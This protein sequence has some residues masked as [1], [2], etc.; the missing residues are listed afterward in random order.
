MRVL[1]SATF[2]LLAAW[3]LA[4]SQDQYRASVDLVHVPVVVLGRDGAPVRGLTK[5]DFEVREDGRPQ[6]VS[7][8]IEGAPGESLPLHVGLLLDTSESMTRDLSDAA[9]AAIQ[10]VNAL[11]ESI[12]ATLVDFDTTVRVGRFAPASYPHMF[13]RIRARKA[14]GM[15]ALWDALGQYPADAAGQEGQ[16]VLVVYTDGGDSSSSMTFGKVDELLRLSTNV[17]VYVIG[18]LENQGSERGNQQM[19]LGL[20]ARET[21]AEA[22]FPG[23]SKQIRD[24]Y[25][26]I[27]DELSARYTIGYIPSDHAADGRF[28]KLEVKLVRPDLKGVKVRTRPGYFAPRG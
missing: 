26:K 16:H 3:P 24:I 28:R 22:Y 15:T 9:T 1:V 20:V 12:D 27:L 13:E 11:D 18:Y 14:G 21:G 19:R 2:V 23:T 6:D 5:Q 17:L 7:F 4:A 8:F 25:A 10:F